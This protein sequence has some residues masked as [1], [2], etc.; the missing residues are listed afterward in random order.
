MG[1]KDHFCQ[2]WNSC[3]TAPNRLTKAKSKIKRDMG[4]GSM[5]RKKATYTLGNGKTISIMA[6]AF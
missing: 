4:L 2:M 1:R 6:K 5:N 3:N